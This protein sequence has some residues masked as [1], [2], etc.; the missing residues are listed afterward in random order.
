MLP[1]PKS[2]KGYDNNLNITSPCTQK[3]IDLLFNLFKEEGETNTTQIVR[4]EAHLG[5][6]DKDYNILHLH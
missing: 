1:A 2:T 3:V 5:L 4:M 6:I